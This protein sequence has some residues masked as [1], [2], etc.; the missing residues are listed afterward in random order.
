VD[1]A[2]RRRFNIVPFIHKPANPDPEL[3]TKLRDERPQILR[4]AMLGC[5]DWQRNGLVRPKSV[6]AATEQ[7]FQDQDLVGLFLAEECDVDS[8]NEFRTATSA[9]LFQRWSEF[10]RAAGE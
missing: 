2:A 3:E 6:Q 8:G 4:W 5:L 1:D 9:D 10:C 7:Y